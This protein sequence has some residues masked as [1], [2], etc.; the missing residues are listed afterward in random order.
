MAVESMFSKISKIQSDIKGNPIEKLN[1]TAISGPPIKRK[2][3]FKDFMSPDESPKKIR[4]EER[5]RI[6]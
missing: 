2:T 3:T 6:T 1:M 5:R 4:D